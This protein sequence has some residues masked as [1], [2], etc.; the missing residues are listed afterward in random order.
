MRGGEPH[1]EGQER[2]PKVGPELG[3]LL[4]SLLQHAPVVLIVAAAPDATIVAAT[5]FAAEAVGRPLADLVGQPAGI[6]PARLGLSRP[7]E[8]DATAPEVLPLARAVQAGETVR[9]ELWLLRRADGDSRT[10]RCSAEPVHD[11]TG[12]V[13]WGV[14]TWR[15]TD[16]LTPA[17]EPMPALWETMLRMASHRLRSS[18]SLVAALA[19]THASAAPAP[20]R[21]QLLSAAARTVAVGQLHHD[22]FLD[23]D[24]ARPDMGRYLARI[25]RGLETAVAE[26]DE[27]VSVTVDAAPVTMP[28]ELAACI[29]LL[30]VELVATGRRLAGRSGVPPEIEIAFRAGDDGVALHV[31]DRSAALPAGFVPAR[32][33]GPGTRLIHALVTQLGGTLTIENLNSGVRFLVALPSTQPT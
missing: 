23:G 4:P 18:L 9:D 29:G 22:V 30:T 20:A 1:P 6:H 33:T 3:E 19:R 2:R 15:D 27:P 32:A 12:A 11:E 5:Q 25:A 10:V 8:T 28:A 24:E 7:N 14:L 31:T 13:R 17:A 26:A 16:E 21:K